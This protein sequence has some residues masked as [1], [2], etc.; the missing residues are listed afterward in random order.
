[1]TI[2]QAGLNSEPG[3]RP[4]NRCAAICREMPPVKVEGYGLI[5]LR[6]ELWR[7]R[8]LSEVEQARTH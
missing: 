2:P 6:W 4:P 5:R 8:G 3:G 1:M 7:D